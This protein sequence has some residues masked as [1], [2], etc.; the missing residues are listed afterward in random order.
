VGAPAPWIAPGDDAVFDEIEEIVGDEILELVR[1]L[2]E[3]A[4]DASRTRQQS[5][6]ILGGLEVD[7]QIR[8]AVGVGG[9]SEPCRDR[10]E[11]PIGLG[12]DHERVA[13]DAATPLSERR[14]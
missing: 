1:R 14:R 2:E 7:R 10:R 4:A 11:E 8:R 13:G 12:T 3:P 9:E 5:R 6:R